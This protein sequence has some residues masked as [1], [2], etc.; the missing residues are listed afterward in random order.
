MTISAVVTLN[1]HKH[2]K[3]ETVHKMDKKWITDD[4]DDD[5]EW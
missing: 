5:N 1:I 3:Q 2:N 4:D